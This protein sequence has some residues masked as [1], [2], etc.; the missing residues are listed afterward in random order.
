MSDFSL[1]ETLSRLVP[2]T[3]DVYFRLF[4]AYDDAIWPAHIVAYALCFLALWI[5]LRSFAGSAR[6]VAAV[7]AAVWIWNGIAFQMLFFSKI[8]WIAWPIGLLFVIQG[9]CFF[10]VGAARNRLD[11]RF[12]P[13]SLAGKCGIV[14]AAAALI[15]YPLLQS[16][17]GLGW[18]GTGLVGVAPGPTTLFT[19]GLLL[20][21]EIR[22]PVFLFAVPLMWSAI[23]GAAGLVLMVPQDIWLPA[24]ALL[25]VILSVFKNRFSRS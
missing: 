12:A 4:D 15:V 24:A 13:D 21:V 10:V 23:A 19:L 25:A 6:L 14:F 11:F 7:L 2:Y 20:M 16:P 17:L 9:L 1:M 18:P 5:T 22:A 3:R 8:N